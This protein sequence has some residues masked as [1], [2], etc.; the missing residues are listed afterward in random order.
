MELDIQSTLTLGNS[1]DLREL[2]CQVAKA[3]ALQHLDAKKIDSRELEALQT[4]VM[5]VDEISSE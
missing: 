2:R 1:R 3:E 5:D 4:L